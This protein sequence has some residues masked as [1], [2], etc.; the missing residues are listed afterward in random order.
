MNDDLFWETF[1]FLVVI[2]ILFL[3]GMLFYPPVAAIGMIFLYSIVIGFITDIG[4]GGI[5]Q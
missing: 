4:T 1:A 3:I 5:Y 2:E